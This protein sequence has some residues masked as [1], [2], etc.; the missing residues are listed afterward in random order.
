M[1]FLFSWF[2]RDDED[3]CLKL[4]DI[5]CTRKFKVFITYNKSCINHLM[6]PQ[7]MRTYLIIFLCLISS[8][9]A[10]AQLDFRPGYVI[11]LQND[12]IKGEVN[13][14]SNSKG[15]KGCVFRQNRSTTKY[16]ASQIKGYGF[17]NDKAFRSDII[18][19]SFV[20]A[21][22]VGE[23][24]LYRQGNVFYLQKTGGELQKLES[25]KKEMVIDGK[26][27][28]R[29][30][31]KWKGVVSYLISDCLNDPGLVKDLRLNEQQLTAVVIDYNKCRKAEYVAYKQGKPWTRLHPG[32]VLG[33][34]SSRINV[35]APPAFPQ[36]KPKYTSVDPFVGAVFAI[37]SPRI[38]ERLAFQ[39][40]IELSKADYSSL[41]VFDKGFNK[42]SHDINVSMTTL[43]VPLTLRY[44]FMF[45][46]FSLQISG[47]IKYDY[48]LES[49]STIRTEIILTNSV[50]EYE[51]PALNFKKSH[52][53]Y[54]GGIALMRSFGNVNAGVGVRYCQMSAL[55]RLDLVL[56]K[57]N[58]LSAFLILQR[59]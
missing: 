47:G 15:Y 48:F 33:M 13:Y 29:E 40:G 34:S 16:D 46:R 32:L 45:D 12:T 31:V 9:G 19:G 51:K 56:A 10:V 54:L 23:L 52:V 38:T 21:L 18:E 57:N 24:S 59:R 50:E 41:V 4:N 37:S 22:V 55:T 42:E 53:G 26:V 3:V 7:L 8:I 49:E 17:I 1:F 14:R 2:S 44:S 36:F 35:D 43:S 20:E 25:S 6:N 28:M 5:A 30:D 11:T 39:P 58:G 27:G